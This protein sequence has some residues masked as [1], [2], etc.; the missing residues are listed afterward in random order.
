MTNRVKHWLDHSRPYE[1]RLVSGLLLLGSLAVY[2]L[3][4]SFLRFEILG[5]DQLT[6]GLALVFLVIG[7]A[8]YININAFCEDCKQAKHKKKHQ[9]KQAQ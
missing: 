3:I 9:S 7:V 5:L 2:T 1:K 4:N 6:F 8:E